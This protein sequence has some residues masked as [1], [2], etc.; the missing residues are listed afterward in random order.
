[1]TEPIEQKW[2]S[3]FRSYRR[4]LFKE[5]DMVFGSEFA[6][7][8]KREVRAEPPTKRN[9]KGQIFDSET[10]R[11][12]VQGC[13]EGIWYSTSEKKVKKATERSADAN[14]ADKAKTSVTDDGS[15]PC[16]RTA[17]NSQSNQKMLQWSLLGDRVGMDDSVRCRKK[18]VKELRV[19]TWSLLGDSVGIRKAAATHERT[20]GDSQ[21]REDSK[22]E[23]EL[24]SN[25]EI[26]QK[27]IS[28]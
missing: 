16:L 25:T 24:P 15:D 23:T 10:N 1:M 14:V 28:V 17:V 5:K 22:N 19:P 18:A 20:L 6:E 9:D 3:S 11:P 27:S 7:P 8:V 26:T 21:G 2:L 13:V 4:A 12:M